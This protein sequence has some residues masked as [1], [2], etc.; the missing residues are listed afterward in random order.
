M[1]GSL[2]GTI[3]LPDLVTT[4]LADYEALALRLASTPVA[5]AEVRAR[6]ARNRR[7]TPLFDTARFCRNLEAAYTTMVERVER[8]LPPESFTV[9]ET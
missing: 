3:G 9:T 6:L 8:G 4:T 7:T 2:L 5:L 1:A